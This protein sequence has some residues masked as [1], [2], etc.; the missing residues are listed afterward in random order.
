M[1]KVRMFI[2]M[3]VLSGCDYL[4]NIRGIGIIKAQELIIRFRGVNDDERL[5]RIVDSLKKK[6][7]T[8]GSTTAIMKRK[9]NLKKGRKTPC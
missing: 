6:E 3:C 5:A 8:K 9:A 4:T 7:K 1:T 2:Q